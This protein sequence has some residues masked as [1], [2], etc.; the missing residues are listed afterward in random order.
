MFHFLQLYAFSPRK[1]AESIFLWVDQYGIIIFLKICTTGPGP[2][3]IQF[4]SPLL[5]NNFNRKKKKK[6]G[7]ISLRLLE[8]GDLKTVPII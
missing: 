2:R 6:V 5:V 3:P 8:R 1:S 7:Y 4:C